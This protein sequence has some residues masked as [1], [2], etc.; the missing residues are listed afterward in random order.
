MNWEA[1]GQLQ[2]VTI[3][4]HCALLRTPKILVRFMIRVLLTMALLSIKKWLWRVLR[5]V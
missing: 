3:G 1:T 4:P 5:I 2:Q